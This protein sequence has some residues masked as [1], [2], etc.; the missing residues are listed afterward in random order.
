[1]LKSICDPEVVWSSSS[2]SEPG[3]DSTF[4]ANGRE[5]A[6]GWAEGPATD[7]AAEETQTEVAEAEVTGERSR[8]HTRGGG[9]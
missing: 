9:G 3:A 4:S 6:A 7:G 1:M 8:G 2:G 5:S